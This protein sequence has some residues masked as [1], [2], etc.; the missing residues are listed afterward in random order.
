MRDR[1]RS[2]EISGDSSPWK[3]FA[4]HLNRYSVEVSETQLEYSE[5]PDPTAGAMNLSLSPT[6]R[7]LF[8]QISTFKS[9]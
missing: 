4:T 6:G 8:K 1:L 3:A 2:S 5:R 9:R 7:T